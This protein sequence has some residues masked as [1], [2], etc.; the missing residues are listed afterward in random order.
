[1][2]HPIQKYGVFHKEQTVVD[3]RIYVGA[4]F[5]APDRKGCVDYIKGNKFF[6]VRKLTSEEMKKTN[7]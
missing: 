1:M 5:T 2:K 6:I 3:G 7:E 4:I